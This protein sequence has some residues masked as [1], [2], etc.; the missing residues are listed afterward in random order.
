MLTTETPRPHRRCR[1]VWLT[2]LLI[3]LVAAGWPRAGLATPARQSAPAA[4]TLPAIT[5][6]QATEVALHTH[7]VRIELAPDP[8]GVLVTLAAEYRLRNDNRTAA[9]VPVQWDADAPANVAVTL[10]GAPVATAADGL[11]TTAQIEMPADS[12][13]TLALR[14]QQ[15]LPAAAIHTLRYPTRSL[16]PWGAQ[17]SLRVDLLPGDALPPEAW[18]TVN[19]PSW[20]YAPPTVTDGTALEWL[21]DGGLPDAI[22]FEFVAPQTWQELQQLTAAASTPASYAALG[23]AYQRLANSAGA[24]GRRALQERYHAQA[25][26]AYTEGIRRGEAAGAPVGEVAGL[27]AS[28]AA[29]YRDQVVAPDGV[30]NPTFAEL[31]TLAA[32]QALPGIMADDP[33]RAELLRWQGEGLR[34]LLADAR[35][36][37]DITTAL[38]LI[39]RLGDALADENSAAFLAAEREALLVQQA[40]AL[41]EQGDRDAALALAGAVLTDATL[42]P[43]AELRPLFTRWSIET[44]ITAAG[45][46]L[47]VHLTA[48]PERLEEARGAL[49]DLVQ[50]WG[51]DSATSRFAVNLEEPPANAEAGQF[52]LRVGLP[53]GAT[54]GALASALPAGADWALL[55]TLL[56]QLAPKIESET[57][58]LQQR[59]NVALPIDLRGAGTQW[60]AVAQTLEE[61]AAQFTA[62]AAAT[63]GAAATLESSLRARV[64]AANY[65]HTAAQWQDLLRASQVTLTLRTGG[66]TGA[67]RAWLLTPAS[68]PQMLDVAVEGLAFS[69]VLLLAASALLGIVLAAGVLWRML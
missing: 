7:L 37:G 50:R 64:Q 18:L 24:L 2:T 6:Q 13:R 15:V 44:A 47:A 27:H 69:R 60:D 1:P 36:R 4:V 23:A 30:A 59:V 21:Y 20:R 38:A 9:S 65:R 16:D 31:M 19:P 32:D 51:Q 61:Q 52:T 17:P 68:P 63:S 10:D 11:R 12:E 42:Q 46:D 57:N 55:R 41:L 66:P 62:T 67:A 33:R 48:A 25:V 45:A 49:R 34:L 5:P 58:W 53:A 54:G 22:I 29:L 35:R 39:D 28:L 3:F 8:A 56:T 26:A 43:P 14:Y 40:L